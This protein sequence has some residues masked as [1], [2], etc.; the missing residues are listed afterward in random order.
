LNSR[1]SHSYEID[2]LDMSLNKKCAAAGEQY[3]WPAKVRLFT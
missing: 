1:S 2:N 3:R